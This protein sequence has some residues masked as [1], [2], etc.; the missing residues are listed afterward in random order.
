MIPTFIVQWNPSYQGS[1]EPRGACIFK[2]PETL[3]GP[4]LN[5]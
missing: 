4:K 5:S 1:V 3:K 2:L